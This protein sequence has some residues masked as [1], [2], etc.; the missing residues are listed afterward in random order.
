MEFPIQVGWKYYVR[1]VPA[2]QIYLSDQIL[3][4]MK[5]QGWEFHCSRDEAG[6]IVLIFKKRDSQVWELEWSVE[7]AVGPLQG[8]KKF[9]GSREMMLEEM[10]R[11]G[12]D[13]RVIE[14][15]AESYN[16]F[17][18]LM[19]FG[20]D[21]DEPVDPKVTEE[22]N[23]VDALYEDPLSMNFPTLELEDTVS[24]FLNYA[25]DLEPEDREE[26]EAH[27]AWI[28]QQQYPHDQD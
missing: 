4:G 13:V 25:E 3:E 21:I 18:R 7:S 2:G 26:L 8:K 15:V 16:R 12:G 6:G 17:D 28:E 22:S 24:D 23:V 5:T 10:A 27:T 9:F 11:I 20:E 14:E 1:V 19:N